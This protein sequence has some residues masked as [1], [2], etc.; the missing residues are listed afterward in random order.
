M[1]SG[2]NKTTAFVGK[3]FGNDQIVAISA[4]MYD[5]DKQF[6]GIIEGSL[7]L[8]VFD[9]YDDRNLTG[10]AAMVMDNFNQVVF[11]NPE[12]GLEKMT[13]HSGEKY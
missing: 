13:I 8:N 7:G 5:E 9:L 10:F 6:I 4:P 2:I 12:L 1:K 11:A 3:G